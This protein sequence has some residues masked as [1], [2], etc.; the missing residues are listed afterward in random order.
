MTE[1]TNTLSNDLLKIS[2]S[3]SFSNRWKTEGKYD[4][5]TET[6]NGTLCIGQNVILDMCFQDPRPGKVF[7]RQLSCTRDWQG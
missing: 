4:A 5:E 2:S 3:F 6:S 7:T 1:I